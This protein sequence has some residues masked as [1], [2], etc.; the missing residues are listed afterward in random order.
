M[1]LLLVAVEPNL[2]TELPL[3]VVG[4]RTKGKGV[5]ILKHHIQLHV[6]V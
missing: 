3:P 1:R 6:M 5:G 2:R 4:S